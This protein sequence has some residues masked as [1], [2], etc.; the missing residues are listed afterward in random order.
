MFSSLERAGEVCK[1][2]ATR[3]NEYALCEMLGWQLFELLR[4]TGKEVEALA[5]G[6]EGRATCLVSIVRQ[7]QGCRAMASLHHHP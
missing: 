4:R 5:T 6:P 3:E 2:M 7:S 1:K